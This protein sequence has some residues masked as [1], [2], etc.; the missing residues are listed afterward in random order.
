MQLQQEGGVQLQKEVCRT[1]EWGGEPGLDPHPQSLARDRGGHGVFR[2][3]AARG[4]R[5]GRL[6]FG[7][8]V[9]GWGGGVEVDGR[10]GEGAVWWYF[11]V[12]SAALCYHQLTT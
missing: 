8:D 1:Q 7:M 12:L 4:R 6:W 2:A 5:G 10:G 11:T 9:F 3:A